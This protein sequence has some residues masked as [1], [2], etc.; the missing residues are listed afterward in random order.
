MAL[1]LFWRSLAQMG[2]VSDIAFNAE[3]LGMVDDHLLR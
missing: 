2:R 1:V 3:P